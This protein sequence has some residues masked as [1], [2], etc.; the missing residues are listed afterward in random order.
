MNGQIRI[1]RDNL[2]LVFEVTVIVAIAIAFL[3]IAQDILKPIVFAF[4][5]AIALLPLC[6][7]FE[8]GL[9]RFLSTLFALI[10]MVGLTI[11]AVSFL[12]AQMIK[13]FSD[14]GE[15]GKN[16]ENL[17]NTLDTYL[18]P[19]I[20]VHLSE[21]GGQD[22]KSYLRPSSILELMRNI[23]NYTGIILSA[24]LTLI[25]TFFYSALQIGL[26]QV[27]HGPVSR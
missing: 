4:L 10:V 12:Y 18:F 16:L 5:I 17:I 22:F 14:S 26:Q 8:R 7:F 24:A 11:V 13:A 9:N 20:G 3:Y 23:L 25:Y 19:Y 21:L 27:I 15:L 2:R 1:S 6:R